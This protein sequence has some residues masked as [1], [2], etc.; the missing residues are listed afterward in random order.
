MWLYGAADGK[1][2]ELVQAVE[3]ALAERRPLELDPNF[4][5]TP[6]LTDDVA[7]A[8]VR[9]VETHYEGV[10]HVAGPD[11]VTQCDFARQLAVAATR[12]T[13]AQPVV[14]ALSTPNPPRNSGLISLYARTRLHIQP[15]GLR[16][17]LETFYVQR[18][19]RARTAGVR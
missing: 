18:D 4:L 1:S 9:M 8:A 13:G 16:S 7:Y 17:G 14:R 12:N 5:G 3:R 11:M 6:T 15:Q 2:P 10:L 19:R